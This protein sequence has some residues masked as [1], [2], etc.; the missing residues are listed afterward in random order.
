MFDLFDP[1][2]LPLQ[3]H[4]V[5]VDTAALMPP[6][7]AQKTSSHI[8]AVVIENHLDAQDSLKITTYVKVSVE[9]GFVHCVLNQTAAGDKATPEAQGS[10]WF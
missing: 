6:S 10:T 8:L 9:R 3:E 2:S 4:L 5:A 7:V 1:L